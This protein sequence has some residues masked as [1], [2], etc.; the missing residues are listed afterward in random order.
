MARKITPQTGI[1]VSRNSLTFFSS[2]LNEVVELALPKEVARDLEIINQPNLKRTLTSWIEQ[3]KLEPT[4]IILILDDSICFHNNTN[5]SVLT[6]EDP[7][8]KDF[9]DTVPFE[10]LLIQN[11]TLEAGVTTTVVNQDFLNPLVTTLEQLGMVVVS[12]SPAFV[13][14][15]DFSKTKFNQEIALQALGNFELLTKYSFISEADMVAKLKEPKPFLSVKFDTK[16]IALVV[17]FVALMIVLVLLLIT[18]DI[19]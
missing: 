10:D 8:Y 4:N 17:V 15:V 3:L 11:F 16:L 1:F 7:E 12:V 5:K 18:Q 2:A 19:I 14:G 13:L 6:E 9:L